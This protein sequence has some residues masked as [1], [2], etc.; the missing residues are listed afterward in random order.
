MGACNKAIWK[1]LGIHCL[2]ESTGHLQN[3][4]VHPCDSNR[5][6]Y[7]LPDVPHLFK[8]IKQALFNNKFIS[9][10]E[11]IIKKN[12]LT[13]NIVDIK[14]IEQPAN[15]QNNLELKLVRNLDAEDLQNT[16]HFDKIKV[17]KAANFVSTDVSA[18]LQFLV[19]HDNYHFS[20]KT[21]A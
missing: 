2:P 21:T 18:S 7:F 19:D 16:N 5:D 13:S 15:H 12:N 10:H 4:T 11:E 6:L 9:L 8:N 14:H 3:S 20:F 1:N 17:S